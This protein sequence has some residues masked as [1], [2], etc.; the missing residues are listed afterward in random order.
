MLLYPSRRNLLPWP[1]PAPLMNKN[2][3]SMVDIELSSE[4]DIGA[5]AHM[6]LHSP[7]ALP[8]NPHF[9][10]LAYNYKTSLVSV[11]IKYVNLRAG[12]QTSSI[13]QYM[14]YG[15]ITIQPL[16]IAPLAKMG[17]WWEI[18]M[19]S[20]QCI[21]V[22][23]SLPIFLLAIYCYCLSLSHSMNNST[24]YYYDRSF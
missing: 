22:L 5:V 10:K 9:I 19:T 14:G 21:T 15:P 4:G 8:K 17:A 16:P 7:H 13:L 3:V 20:H 12:E 24:L 1:N 11:T 23:Q 2:I 18:L 6:M